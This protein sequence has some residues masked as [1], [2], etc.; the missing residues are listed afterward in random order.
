MKKEILFIIPFL[1]LLAG[2]FG[3]AN[4]V[5]PRFWKDRSIKIGVG[6]KVFLPNIYVD[7]KDLYREMLLLRKDFPK[8]TESEKD[9][10]R[11]FVKGEFRDVIN[12][13]I[14]ELNRRGFQAKE[15]PDFKIPISETKLEIDLTSIANEAN[16]DVLLLFD[17]QPLGIL[18][19]YDKEGFLIRSSAKLGAYGFMS[20][21]TNGRMRAGFFKRHLWTRIFPE[22]EGIIPIEGDW[23]QP[24]DHPKLKT[25][26][27]VA[28]AI[29]NNFFIDDFF[30]NA[31]EP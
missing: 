6:M 24:P 28:V 17:I 19:H 8:F 13:F 30:K 2:C 3:T 7:R 29:A 25:A 15:I 22:K 9:I 20:E 26:L 23:R 12:D 11:E 18:N 16:V 27:K 5:S 14:E 1:I 21:M 4:R 10:F 31:P